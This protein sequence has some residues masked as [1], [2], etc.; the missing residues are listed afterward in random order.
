MIALEPRITVLFV[1]DDKNVRNVLTNLL[2]KNNIYVHATDNLEDARHALNTCKVDLVLSDGMF[3]SRKGLAV[4]K[5]F[6]P[7]VKSIKQKDTEIIAWSNSTHVHEYCNQNGIESYSKRMLTRQWFKKKNRPYIKVKRVNSHFLH[8]LIIEKTVMKT[9]FESTINE[10]VL[11]PHYR[12][13]ITILAAFLA[14]DAR[15]GRFNE[16]I[17]A[18][19]RAIVTEIKDGV[20]NVLVDPK[21]DKAI[22]KRIINKITKQ[23]FFQTIKKQVNIRSRHL[24]KFSRSLRTRKLDRL[25]NSQLANLYARFCE[26]FTNMRVYSSLP[27][28]LEHGTNAWSK[29]LISILKKSVH[30]QSEQNRLLSILTTPDRNSYVKNFELALAG[31]GRDKCLGKDIGR[32]ASALANQYVWINYTFKGTPIDKQYILKSV[33]ALG[34]TEKDFASVLNQ[35]KLDYR[36]LKKDK[37]KARKNLTEWEIA[38]FKVGEDIVFIKSYRKRVFSES[39]YNVEFLLDEIAERIS[40]SKLH[41]AN[42][43]PH[44]VLASL[45][46][47]CF[48]VSLI[49]KR[50]ESSILFHTRGATYA[51]GT[52]AKPFYR[53]SVRP[54]IG[55]TLRGQVAYPGKAKG[56]AHLVNS[57]EEIVGFAEGMILISRSTNPTLVPAMRQAAAI[58]T[59]IGGLTCHAAIM[60][61]EMKKPCIVGIKN[62]TRTLKNGDQVEV[63]ANKGIVTIAK[64]YK[65]YQYERIQNRQ[66]TGKE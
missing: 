37:F 47:N 1:E 26:I 64:K 21:S 43:L 45:N 60:A 25:T 17:G 35:N 19:Y 39:Y 6:I 18:N 51:L 20:A 40:T 31:L 10:V 57:S 63:D 15:T 2:L 42:M 49:T 28:A 48:P 54:S 46:L 4:K 5:N 11:E 9:G 33:R 3:P 23:N 7:L 50:M 30:E 29:H 38:D 36:Q 61:R 53:N 52:W 59:E 62:A 34:N 14:S 55:T 58:V 65:K 12:E 66:V 24:L 41:V 44:E 16:A 56:V 13:P 22:S 32:R 27:T 8:K